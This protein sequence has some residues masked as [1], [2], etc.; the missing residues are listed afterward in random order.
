MTVKVGD[1]VLYG[2]HSGTQIT[3]EGAD[4]LIMR[5]LDIFDIIQ[6]TS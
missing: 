5:E 2:K 3:V 1:A 6:Q 4:V